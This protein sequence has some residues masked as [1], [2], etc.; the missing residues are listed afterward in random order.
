MSDEL[1]KAAKDIGDALK[2]GSHR[3][4]AGAERGKRAEFGDV[5]TGGEKA[6]S[7]GNEVKHDVQA[8]GDRIKREVRDMT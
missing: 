6:E 8:E 5:M 2:E 4:S 7:L 1:H 3:V